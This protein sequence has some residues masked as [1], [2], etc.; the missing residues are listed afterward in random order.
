MSDLPASLGSLK[1]ASVQ[2]PV[3]W[4]FDPQIFAREK[5]LLFDAGANYVGHELM[6]P[7]RGDWQSL[8]WM[9]H[10]KALVR[11]DSGIELL[12][13]VCRHRQAIMLEGRGNSEAIVC[14]LHRWTYDLKGE[15]LGAPRFAE[16]P[17]VKLASTPLTSWNGLLFRG[18]RDPRVDLA[19][20]STRE[21]WNF[22]GYVFDSMRVDHYPIN[23]KTFIEVYLE[24]YHVDFF[25][26]GL[27]NF[28][29]CDNFSLDR[30]E[31]YSVQIAP[32]K[33][34]L[35][36]A[37]SPVYRKWHEA[38]LKY[39]DGSEPRHG[40]LWLTYFPGLMLEWY[41]N[42]LVVSHL[43]PRGPQLTS[44]VVEFYYPEEIALFEREF[45]EAQQAAYAETALEDG[46]IC[47]RMDRG[48]KALLEQGLD[49]AGP[50]QS[51]ME[52]ALVHFHEWIR[53]RL[54]ERGRV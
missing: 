7:N 29:D 5:Q 10:A 4:Y 35:A 23:W 38:C 32:A 44:N 39:L 33:N 40:A 34:R 41:P 1:P 18:P 24:V 28:T 43:V 27:G 52:D 36:K 46:E 13:N 21:D 2:L 9:D 15:L 17:C 8:A 42:V 48:R 19:G 45:V 3:S 11:S 22:D 16:S 20:V 50:Y 14:P 31:E 47:T 12:S 49:D 6:V 53:T 37:G 26:P 30:G 51:P 54:G 25:H